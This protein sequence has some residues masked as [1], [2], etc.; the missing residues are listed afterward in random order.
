MSFRLVLRVKR[1]SEPLVLTVKADCFTM[2]TSVQVEK[3][4]GGLSEISPNH[5]DTLDFGK[6]STLS[7]HTNTRTMLDHMPLRV[8]FKHGS[9]LPV[10]VY[11][12]F[13]GGDFR[14]IHL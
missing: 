4:G 10:S 1:K 5:Q 12:L 11:T 3:P 6:V 14:A 9:H 13:V 8:K 7:Y 2:S